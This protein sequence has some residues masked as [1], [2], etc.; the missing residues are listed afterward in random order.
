MDEHERE[1][2]KILTCAVKDATRMCGHFACRRAAARLRAVYAN[3]MRE[4]NIIY[5]VNGIP[6]AHPGSVEVEGRARELIK[7]AARGGA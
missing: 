2:R 1:A 4:A 5:H 7:Q 3:G 6:H